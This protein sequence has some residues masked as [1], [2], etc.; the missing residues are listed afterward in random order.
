MKIFHFFLIGFLVIG[1]TSCDGQKAENKTVPKLVETITDVKPQVKLTGFREV[2]FGKTVEYY[3]DKDV[4]FEKTKVKPYA[5]AREGE[6]NSIGTVDLDYIHYNF[7]DEGR[8]SGIHARAQG[9]DKSY[10]DRLLDSL[11]EKY[12]KEYRHKSYAEFNSEAW[13]WT[14]EGADVSLT[15]NTITNVTDLYIGLNSP[16]YLKRK[17]KKK[18]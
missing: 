12:G 4:K 10:T 18:E 13:S 16:E 5:Y 17:Q 8:F 1:F 6:K 2:E 3:Q 15:Y 7:E 14:L 11:V 9:N